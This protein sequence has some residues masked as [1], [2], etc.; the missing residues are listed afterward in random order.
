MALTISQI[1]AGVGVASGVAV[2]GLL[3]E[4][5]S[6]TVALAGFAPT[7]SVLGAAL[8]AI[9]LARLA[10]RR[11]R[12]WG[13]AAGY[14]L[15]LAGTGLILT[16]AV[17]GLLP[18]LF[19]GTAAFGAADAAGLQ[20]RFAAAEVVGGRYR[21]RALSVVMWA[22]T[23][24]SVAGPNLS[25]FGSSVG[26]TLKIEPLTGPYLLAAIAFGCA[27]VVIS[28]GLAGRAPTEPDHDQPDTPL[29]PALREGFQNP[30]TRLAI[31][32]VTCSHTIMVGV[33]VMTPLHMT[34]HGMSLNLV[35]L[36][37][38][39]HIFA[40]YGASPIL[41]WLADRLGGPA[42]IGFGVIIFAAAMILGGFADTTHGPV[43]S[44]AIGM[45][46]LGWSAGVIGG[47][48]LLVASVSDQNRVS[49]QGGADALMNLAAA[50]SSALSGL[51][52][53]LAGFPALNLVAAIV[54]APMA[55]LVLARTTSSC[56]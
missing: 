9:P 12:K 48:T 41:G 46:G 4:R 25:E 54:A 43:I 28:I 8:W 30:R 17:T 56:R 55:V 45:L 39:I 7:S 3:A 24:G 40:M 1:L 19:V 13:L 18:L 35:G 6:G 32:S 27:I 16:A 31:V 26:R 11:G 51:V 47:S 22:T 53:G 10:G 33:M 15:A 14:L 49:L 5:L 50:G 44:L 20:A 21:A 37:I 29:L 52:M 38:S 42:V 36:V 34:H 2:G 23:L